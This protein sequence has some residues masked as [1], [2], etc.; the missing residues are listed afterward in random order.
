[1]DFTKRAKAGF[2]LPTHDAPADRK[3][4]SEFA[5]GYQT[6]VGLQFEDDNTTFEQQGELLRDQ[7]HQ[8]KKIKGKHE[9]GTLAQAIDHEDQK[10]SFDQGKKSIL[11]NCKLV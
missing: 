9:L 10:Q 6:H 2:E 3:R 7:R 4:A 11:I 1:M 5:K 8:F